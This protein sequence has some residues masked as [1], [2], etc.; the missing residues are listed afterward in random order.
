MKIA[1]V[2]SRT[3]HASVVLAILVGHVGVQAGKPEWA[4]QGNGKKGQQEEGE[5]RSV[6]QA[7]PSGGL[8][9]S[10]NIGFG[11][12]QQ[13]AAQDYY[14]AQARAGK[15]PPGLAKKNNGCLPPGQAKK[16]KKGM[17]LPRDVQY[18]PLPNELVVRMGIPPA[19]HKY[20]RVAG[21]ILLVAVGTMVVVD[22]IEDL[23]R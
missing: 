9:L 12:Q 17:S 4:G 5:G 6:Q 2:F 3:V 14:G 18:Y 8:S 10:V 15:C 20:I 22:A 21:D 16:W 13:R 11:S 19:G 1:S 7:Q 23:M